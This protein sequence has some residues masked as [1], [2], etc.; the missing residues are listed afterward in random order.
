MAKKNGVAQCICSF[1]H[2]SCKTTDLTKPYWVFCLFLASVST[3]FHT[4]FE[5]LWDN[6]STK[7]TAVIVIA[8][9]VERMNKMMSVSPRAAH[10][11]WINLDN[12]CH[13]NTSAASD[14]THQ[15][16]LDEATEK[17]AG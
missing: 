1:L 13:S 3:V 17:P 6:R 8:I 16:L 5:Q 9:V 7:P 11:L 12:K 4:T 10:Q 14:T 2:N 15:Q